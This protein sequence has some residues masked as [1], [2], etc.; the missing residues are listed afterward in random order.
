M[1]ISILSSL[2]LENTVLGGKQFLKC[3]YSEA[4]VKV[5]F[6]FKVFIKIDKGKGGRWAYAVLVLRVAACEVI[7]HEL[8]QYL[9]PGL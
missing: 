5:F 3:G 6:V 4:I 7:C 1:W 8:Y 9:W 2:K